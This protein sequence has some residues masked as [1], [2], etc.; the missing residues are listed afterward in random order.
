[1]A[2]PSNTSPSEPAPDRDAGPAVRRRGWRRRL[3]G[4]LLLLGPLVALT[5]GAYIYYTSGRVVE[6]DNAYVKTDVAIISAEVAGPIAV[7]SVRENQR[8]EA[9]DVLFTIDDRAFKVALAR[10]DAQLAAIDDFVESTRASY[11]QALAQLDLARTNAAYEQRE[12]DRLAALA[13]R[14]LASDV[15]VDEQRHERDVATQEILLAERTLDQIRAR[16]GG[17]LDRPVT[18]QAAYLAVEATR[19][20][21][22][23]DLEHTVVRAPFDGIASKVPTLGQY[24]QPGAPVMTVVADRGVWIEA[25]FKETDLT[26]V[27]P[28]QPVDVRV[29]TYPD[30]HWQG[31]VESISQATGAEFSVIPAQN[32]TGNWV[33]VTQRI[34]VRVALEIRAG[35][36]QLRSGMSATVDIDTGHERPAPG[37]VRALLPSRP[38]FAAGR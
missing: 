28:G 6:T 5:T 37:W 12:L 24:V 9:G 20:A 7:L 35:D 38:A 31:R 21:T 1:M 33:K 4:A 23:L 14:K 27:A 10:A 34:P 26:H 2:E 32:A 13:D 11:R 3:R 16:L 22:A 8:V 29:D 36:P 19:D 25:N 30:R 18:E 17:E 15:D